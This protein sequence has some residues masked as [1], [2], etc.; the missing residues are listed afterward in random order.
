MSYTINKSNG[1]ILTTLIDGTLDLTTDLTLI[2]RNYS[3]F[4]QQINQDLVYLLENFSNTTAP[5]RPVYGQLWFDSTT[6]ENKLKVYSSDGW[7]SVAGTVVSPTTPL[8]LTS[9]DTWYDNNEE[10][11][12]V[13]DGLNTVLVG[14]S[15]GKSQGITGTVA[16]TITDSNGNSQHVLFLYANSVLLGIFSS[17]VFT[18][19][20]AITGFTT[21]GAGFTSNSTI[22]FNF[23]TTVTNSLEL[24]GLTA[25]QF[26]RSDTDSATTGKL[27]IQNLYGN[28]IVISAQGSAS[29]SV[30]TPGTAFVIS[31]NTN[32]GNMIFQTQTSLGKF[33]PIYVDGTN[34]RVGF[35][36]N[37]PTQTVDV[38]GDL[39]IRGNLTVEGTN[40]NV[41]A[42]NLVIADKNIQIAYSANPTD[43]LADGAGITV[44]GTTNKTILYNNGTGSFDI[45]QSI[46]LSSGNSFK[47]NGVTVLTAT[48]LSS[49]ITSAPGLTSFGPQTSITAGTVNIATNIISTTTTNQDLQL[50]PNGTG[51]IAIVGSKKITGL[52]NPTNT[53]DAATKYYVDTQV[54]NAPLSITCSDTNIVPLSTTSVSTLLNDIY[55]SSTAA[56]GKLAYV[57]QQTLTFSTGTLASVAYASSTTIGYTATTLTLPIGT[58]VVITRTTQNTAITGTLTING[59]AISSIA[60]GAS[61]T[62]YVE[63]T[64]TSTT[65]SLSSTWGG[66]TLTIGGTSTTGATFT[67]Y[68]PG[69]I[70]IA[71]SLKQYSIVSGAWAYQ[72]TLTSHV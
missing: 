72:S 39:R 40:L 64:P 63:G 36:T 34:N 7:K 14:P 57:H 69:V 16:K 20:D 42:T 49:S 38:A 61:L 3:G 67:Y 8:T 25:S 27:T 35:Y 23:E 53:Q 68:L 71:R 70:T 65:A 13:F 12:Y 37:T 28:G 6:D 50:S 1:T 21:I 2:G 41:N 30:P 54:L 66:A 4:G 10:Q 32:N 52:A 22:S 24:N 26:L 51:N 60:S 17:N 62:F 46:N 19:K 44:L 58:T 48:A 33:N 59:N 11:F 9:G 29:L 18:P 15:W 5:S 31:N 55:P 43:A 45:S 56:N 47:I